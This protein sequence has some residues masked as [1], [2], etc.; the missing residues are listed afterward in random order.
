MVLIQ[1]RLELVDLEVVVEKV[2][3]LE[4][5]QVVVEHL[6]KVLLAEQEIIQ[7]DTVLVEEELLQLVL[8]EVLVVLVVLVY[9][10]Q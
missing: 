1:Q 7:V 3:L 2:P 5:I 6:I 9:L 8:M 10:L 4:L